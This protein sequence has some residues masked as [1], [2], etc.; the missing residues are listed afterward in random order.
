MF[1]RQ[2]VDDIFSQLKA[3]WGYISK[4]EWNALVRDAHLGVARAEAKAP[5][6][7]ID[8][9]VREVIERRIEPDASSDEDLL[10]GSQRSQSEG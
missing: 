10:G 5:L 6:G 8:H 9:R 2:E 1:S 4:E 3:E 7:K